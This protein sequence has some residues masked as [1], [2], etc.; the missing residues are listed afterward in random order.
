MRLRPRRSLA[1]FVRL[2]GNVSYRAL[3][4]RG[5]TENVDG[6]AYVEGL[7]IPVR[8]GSV[9]ADHNAGCFQMRVSRCQRS[10]GP[11]R[12]PWCVGKRLTVGS[13][14]PGFAVSSQS[15]RESLFVN[16]SVMKSAQE[17]K[18]IESRRTAVGPV[19]HMVRIAEAG[20][21]TR[22]PA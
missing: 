1:R 20:I 12:G 3:G 19:T 5:R 17:K 10:S 22:E 21:A 13:E 4:Q 11:V 16:G 14:E 15:D 6:K 18:I 7:A 2:R 9:R 8:G